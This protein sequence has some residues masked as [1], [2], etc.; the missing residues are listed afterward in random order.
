MI[1]LGLIGYPLLQSQSP[2]LHGAALQELGVDGEYRLY[3]VAPGDEPELRAHIDR[4]RNGKLLGLNVTLPH[5]QTV[6]PLL[7]RLTPLAAA[8]GAV[9]TIFLKD[10]QVWGDNTDAPG[11]LHDLGRVFPKLQSIP[12]TDRLALVLGAGG[13]ARAV[14][15][16]LAFSGW[17][18]VLAARRPEPLHALVQ[19]LLRA[20]TYGQ[21]APKAGVE[22]NSP[23]TRPFSRVS[24][25]PLSPRGVRDW[26]IKPENIPALIVNAT[27]A[28]M[29]PNPESNPW[30]EGV[31]LPPGACVYDLVYKPRQ[32]VLLQDAQRAGL[33]AA[34]GLGML[35]EQAALALE[36]WLGRPALRDAMRQAV[37]LSPESK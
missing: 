13:A 10:G 28:G 30:P 32:T 4:V 35:V 29:I 1:Q 24:S 20:A 22:I 18:L 6:V 15:H 3:P 8:I 7:D 19:S 16:A 2:A 26:M 25:I 17:E 31:P 37:D 33:P 27:S 5:K 36:C 12:S 23:V 34:N 21:A 9:N 11:F 14:A